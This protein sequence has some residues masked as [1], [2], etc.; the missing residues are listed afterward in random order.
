MAILLF[1]LWLIWNGKINAEIL[2]FGAALTAL[3]L[4]FAVKVLGYSLESERRFWR[5]SPLFLCYTAVLIAEIFKSSWDV[6]RMAVTSA[7]KPEPVIVEF[8]S[9]LPTDFQNV[10]LANSITL[11][12]G[13]YTLFQEGDRFVVHCLRREYADGMGDSVFI[14]L[15]RK[16]KI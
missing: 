13:T 5:N 4:F 10:L 9:G 7:K 8:H 2:L 6:G 12:P 1:L 15:L 14:E 3:A 11:T 16:V